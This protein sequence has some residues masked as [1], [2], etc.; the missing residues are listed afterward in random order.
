METRT[1]PQCGRQMIRKYTG[2]VLPSYPA[3]R[4]WNW[5]CGCGHAESGGVDRD[6][7]DE[8]S[9]HLRWELS[10]QLAEEMAKLTES[11]D[12]LESAVGLRHAMNR[13]EA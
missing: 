12:R 7:T 4:P 11:M 2:A 9:L 10:N 8:E 13:Q 6:L 3:Q 1:C 5:W